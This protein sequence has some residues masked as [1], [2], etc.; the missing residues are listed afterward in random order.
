MWWTKFQTKLDAAFVMYTKKNSRA[1][2][3]Q[4]HSND[5]KLRII[6]DKLR[7]RFFNNMKGSIKVQLTMNLRFLYS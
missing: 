4:Y 3:Q 2:G 6:L 5:D 1:N 7:A